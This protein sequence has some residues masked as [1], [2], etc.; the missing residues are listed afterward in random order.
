AFLLFQSYGFPLELTKEILNE[1]GL[2]VD[3]KG[4][5]KEF[6]KHQQ[7]SRVGAE[8]RFKG[9]L[10]DHSVE[11]T[12]LHTATHLLNQALREVLK[13]PDIFQRGSNITPER[14]RFD[15]NFD[16]KVTKEEQKE[17]EDW[18]NE[19][20]KEELPVKREELTIEEAKKK[21][22]Q[23]VFEH[24]YGQKVFVYSIGNKSIEICG[25][26]HVKNTKELGH[27]KIKKEESSA[28][29]VRRI[30]ATLE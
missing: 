27:F 29:G 15:F 4:F 5:Q 9:G 26:P 1:K 13:K 16:R 18:V 12:K 8:K 17:V 30:K 28:A 14:L 23:G 7:L 25:G 19:R 22:A 11:T 2:K 21:G 24:K 20:I 10:G 6:K 3:E